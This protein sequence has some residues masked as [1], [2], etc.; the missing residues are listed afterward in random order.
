ME[1]ENRTVG[2]MP[3]RDTVLALFVASMWGSNNIAAKVAMADVPALMTGGIRF[4]VSAL[5]LLPWLRVSRADL[6]KILPIAVMSGP[7]HFGFL[8]S[9]FGRSHH[10]G[11]MA[12]V[13]LLW[14]PLTTVLAMVVLK[15]NP[16]RRQFAGLFLA[17]GGVVVMG[18]QPALFQEYGAFLLCL[19]A[20]VCWGTAV[21]LTRRAGTLPGISIQAWMAL[22]TGPTL[23]IASQLTGEAAVPHLQHAGTL[24]WTMTLYGAIGSSMIGNVV[25]FNLVRRNPVAKVT[26]LLLLT[27][28]ISMVAG[29]LFLHEHVSLQE[30]A[31]AALTLLGAFVVIG[32]AQKNSVAVTAEIAG[33]DQY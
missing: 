10:I 29:A 2:H 8:Y 9:G 20:A 7:L 32:G 4:A 19:G 13:T 1:S 12:V 30:I 23:M 31:G 14:V 17:F 25:M 6:K 33:S 26:P 5:F 24:F 11:A 3:L 18:F 28:I 15:E 22:I 21:I 16:T 27:P